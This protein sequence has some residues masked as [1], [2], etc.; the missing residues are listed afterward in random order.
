MR[1]LY[2][3]HSSGRWFFGS[4]C[5]A[6]RGRNRYA[7]WRATSLHRAARRQTPRRICS[8]AAHPAAPASSAVRS[9]AWYP[10][11]S[12]S[13][14]PQSPL[15]CARPAAPRQLTRAIA[16]RKAQHLREFEARIDMQQRKR[17]RRRIER[18]LRQPQ[19]HRR[20]FADGVEHHRPLKLRGHFAQD[21]DALRLKQAQMAQGRRPLGSG[22]QRLVN[23]HR[24]F[25]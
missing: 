25:E 4:H 12:D 14:P 23:R 22:A 9:S 18:L 17:N 24:V 11:R 16:S 3:F 8:G 13:C 10:A 7:P 21:V 1:A 5:P 2:R 15:H 19:H 20:V 6:C